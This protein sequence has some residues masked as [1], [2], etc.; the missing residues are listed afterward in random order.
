MGCGVG[1]T[2]AYCG[3]G[4]LL[5]GLAIAEGPSIERCGVGASPCALLPAAPTAV[6]TG[7]PLSPARPASIHCGAVRTLGWHNPS[8]TVPTC[9]PAYISG[10]LEPVPGL[11][12]WPQKAGDKALCKHCTRDAMGLA[13][14][15]VPGA[16]HTLST[17]A[18]AWVSNLGLLQGPNSRRTR[19]SGMGYY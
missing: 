14:I 19:F 4:C 13:W 3:A 18:M 11:C 12:Y 15:P 2:W 17:A 7:R 5:E 8:W 6:G 16:C 1:L 9:L 10:A